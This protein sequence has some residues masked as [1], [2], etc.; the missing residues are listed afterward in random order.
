MTGTA[1]A[2]SDANR[3]ALPAGRP[4][5]TPPVA[6]LYCWPDW[7]RANPYQR[8][9]HQAIGDS[10]IVCRGEATI[11]DKWLID[12]AGQIE[13]FAFSLAR[14]DLAQHGEGGDGAAARGDRLRALFADRPETRR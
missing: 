2:H 14:G 3:D 9:F 5:P 12:R 6:N 10:G 4:L 13:Y 11:N 1:V 7:S 8:L